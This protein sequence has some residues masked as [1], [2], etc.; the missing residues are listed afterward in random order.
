MSKA[1]PWDPVKLRVSHGPVPEP[2]TELK[3]PSG[4]RYLVLK[5]GGKA[6]LHCI[7]LPATEKPAAVVW[8][9]FWTPRKKKRR[10]FQ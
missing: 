6:T 1:A 9:W 4:R 2:G 5:V 3:M 8:D 7:V 10:V